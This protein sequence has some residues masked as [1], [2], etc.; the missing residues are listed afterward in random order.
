MEPRIV[1]L[2]RGSVKAEFSRPTARHIWV[3]Y[4][5]TRP[6]DV[7]D[8]L[9]DAQIAVINKLRIDEAALAQLPT[10]R[11]IA[12]AATGADNVDLAACRAR[13]IVVSNVRGYADTTVPE[14]VISLMLAL[15][16]NLMDFHQDVRAGR[17]PMSRHFCFLDH[18]IRDLRGATLG[19]VGRGSLGSGVARLAEAFGMQVLWSERPGADQVRAGR[20]AFDEVLARA[21]VLSLHCPL[22]A[23]TRGMIDSVALQAMKSSAFL[24]NTARGALVDEAALANALR[25]GVIAGA[26]IDVLS[27]EPPPSDHPLLA[28][29]IPN[30]IVTPHVAWA[31]GEAMAAMAAQVVHNIEAFLC[32]APKNCLP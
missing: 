6:E 8:R 5:D 32:G 17:W 9:R 25:Q 2:E 1:F 19:L 4:P 30:L 21:D 7:V 22:D 12:L 13:G 29:D 15:S 20:V 24:I 28:P 26:A 3:D 10:L 31:S 23:G 11:M 14:H 16:R 18:P 27:S